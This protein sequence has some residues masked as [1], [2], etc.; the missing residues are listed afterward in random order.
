MNA[1]QISA[2]DGF[3][4]GSSLLE[5]QQ[6]RTTLASTADNALRPGDQFSRTAGVVAGNSNRVLTNELRYVSATDLTEGRA[7]SSRKP[8]NILV[9]DDDDGDR[10][11]LKRVLKQT[12]LPSTC[13][14]TSSIDDA[15]EACEKCAF[16]CAIVDYRLPGQDGL[17]G[18]ALLHQRYPHMAL[19]MVTGQGDEAI[20]TEAMRSGASDY[21]RKTQISVESIA[22]SV[23]NA[24][25]RAAL[26]KKVA[27]QKEEME[28]FSEVLV[29][30]LKGPIFNLLLFADVIEKSIA[31]DKAKEAVPYCNALSKAATRMNSLIDALQQ[32]TRAERVLFAPLEMSQVMMDT[33]G[34]LEQVVQKRGAR[35]TYGELPAVSGTPQLAQLMQ[36]LIGNSI[37]YCEAETPL[38]HIS[39]KLQGENVWLFSV[40]D[41][42]IGIPEE[43]AQQVFE[44]FHRLHGKGKYEGTGL[45]LAT[46]KKIVERHGGT[47]SCASKAGQGTTFYFT[48]HGAQ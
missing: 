26:L 25:E 38:V 48:L 33:L 2:V 13:T 6:M 20:A 4:T 3:A 24:V 16:D 40:E 9:V 19:I 32:Y 14:E 22:R 10:A 28:V 5:K 37:K 12:G 36:N 21:I 41:N 23:E 39:A 42:G 27:Q 30:D 45:G 34:N 43:Y 18:V 8:L 47:I 46:C 11:Q 7:N 29:H 17:A 1:R 35:V 44:P 15:L 31:E